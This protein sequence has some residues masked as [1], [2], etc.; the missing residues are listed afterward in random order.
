MMDRDY[1]SCKYLL[2]AIV[3]KVSIKLNKLQ[4]VV[5]RLVICVLERKHIALFSFF[6][7]LKFRR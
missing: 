7:F 5:Y 6:E 1:F 3:Q 2:G 4:N